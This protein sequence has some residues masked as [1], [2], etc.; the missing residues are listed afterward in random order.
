MS[1]HEQWA[2]E[3]IGDLVEHDALELV[4][5]RVGTRWDVPV[6]VAIAVPVSVSVPVPISVSVAIAIAIAIAI[7]VPITITGV[8]TFVVAPV[9]ALA[10]GGQDTQ[11]T[12]TD[13]DGK[14]RGSHAPC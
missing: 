14:C 12:Q 2:I 7:T 10:A 5:G 4:G 8:G 3:T 9:V 11:Q 13:E 1:D 6:A